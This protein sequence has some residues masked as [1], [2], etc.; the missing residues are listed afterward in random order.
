MTVSRV[1]LTGITRRFGAVTALDRAE[2][3]LR[4][5]EVHGVLGENGA[6]KTTLLNVLAGM[7]TPDEGVVEIDG[8]RVRVETPR[9]AWSHGVGMVHQHFKLVPELTVLENLSLGLRVARMGF[10]L[11]FDAVRARV[12]ELEARTG[13]RVETDRIVAELSVGER[14]RVE[15]LKALLRSPRI[16][17]LDEPTAVLTPNEVET[18]FAL[19]RGLAAEGHAIALVAHKLDEVMAVADR[20]TVLRRGRTTLS[21]SRAEAD[22]R[23]LVEA[24]V[25]GAPLRPDDPD[26]E[27]VAAIRASRRAGEVVAALSD[28]GVRS[29]RGWALRGTSMEVRR[30]EIVGV[31]GVEGNGQ[32]EL[33]LLLA[34]RRTADEGE[35][36][37]PE[38]IGYIPQD[39]IQ[40]GLIGSF[41]LVENVGLA[42]HDRLGGGPLMPWGEARRRA[43]DVRV[44]FGVKASDVEVRAAALSGGNQQRLVVGR[45]MGVASDLLVAENPTRGLDIA[46]THFVREQLRSPSGSDRAPGI[47]LISSDLD[48][49]LALSDRMFVIVRGRLTAVPDDGRTREQ[50]GALMLAA[51]P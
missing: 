40:E 38:G 33:A 19:L 39:R 28:A 6:G 42:L 9:D 36:A 1:R 20:F 3:E 50:V 25:G 7:I 26:S 24:M 17:I 34:G 27:P 30:G 43:E 4:P 5:G 18:L 2:L 37:L 22:P 49:V 15:I 45:E 12:A 51:G 14:Q 13:L 48:E 41:D 21:I 44:R 29:S 23:K 8:R 10:G 31:A 32:R 11:P 47:V 16:L 46:A 35:A